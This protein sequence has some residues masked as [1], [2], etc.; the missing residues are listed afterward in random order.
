[1]V[2][3]ASLGSRWSGTLL[4]GI[5]RV[6][7]RSSGISNGVEADSTARLCCP[8][9]RRRCT[10]DS[11]APGHRRLV[12][13]CSAWFVLSPA[14]PVGPT[15]RVALVQPGDI[16]DSA[17]RQ[18][19]SEKLTAT[20]AGQHPDLV[21]WERAAS[22]STSPA[23]RP[24]WQSLLTCPDGS[25]PTSS[26]TSTH[27]RREGESTSRP[28]SS[29]LTGHWARTRKPGWCPLAK[30]V[31][32]R[33]LLGWITGSTKA[34]AEDRRRGSG[35]VVLHTWAHPLEDSGSGQDLVH[36]ALLRSGSTDTCRSRPASPQKNNN[37]GQER[38]REEHHPCGRSWGTER[39]SPLHT[40]LSYSGG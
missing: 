14:P 15:V 33:P 8:R 20:V 9:W 17:A 38:R 13:R 10:G 34:A 5:G 18:A 7:L 32:L 25:A 4:D 30:Y 3:R 37:N 11:D 19:A 29:D 6:V 40:T 39:S 22:V 35:Q 1:M 16:S 28:T 24:P 26:S 2:R 27:A 21:V 31:P 23:L 12:S 36:A